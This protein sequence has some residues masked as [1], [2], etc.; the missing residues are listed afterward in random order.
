MRHLT[1]V[2]ARMTAG[3]ARAAAPAAHR[4]G[5]Q[6]RAPIGGGLGSRVGVACHAC[7]PF[8]GSVWAARR[9]ERRDRR[10]CAR[11]YRA[12][13]AGLSRK[14]ADRL[15]LTHACHPD[16][17]RRVAGA[18]RMSPPHIES[19]AVSSDPAPAPTPG[20]GERIARLLLA[21][22]PLGALVRWVARIRAS[23]HT[24]LLGAFL[25]IALLLIAMGAMSLQSIAS[26]ARQ[27]RLLDQA[28]ERVDASRQ[29]EHALGLQMNFTANALL[30]QDDATI[31][32]MFR[33]NNRFK[34]RST[35]SRRRPRPTSARRSSGS[36]RR[37]TGS[38]PAVARHRERSSAKARVTTRCTLPPERGYPL[39]RRSRP[40][41]PRRSGPSRRAWDSCA[42]ASRR[43]TG[44]PCS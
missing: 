11:D 18:R 30:L 40:S 1:G 29:I 19:R 5:L 9:P 41:S 26:V 15:A 2:C 42:R 4:G 33:E 34:T 12:A 31:E 20:Q 21:Y 28:H 6:E 35:A 10:E 3:N 39:Y 14:G 22:S 24:K 16:S 27:S 8:V 23:V 43:R 37:R 44:A 17:I 13:T 38:W 25:L 32:S 7:L 36:G